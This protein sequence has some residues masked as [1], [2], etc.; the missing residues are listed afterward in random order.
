MTNNST[1]NNDDEL[2]TQP[3]G[4][5]SIN[6]SLVDHIEP[7]EPIPQPVQQD[8]PEAP[9][10]SN[11]KKWPVLMGLLVIFLLIGI[12]LWLAN[13]PKT[14]QLQGM[15]EADS[16]NVATKVPS[17]VNSLLVE[18]GQHVTAGQVLA[19][20]SSPELEAKQ[21]QAEASLQSAR[22]LEQTAKRGSRE[23]NIASLHANWQSLLAQAQ[24]AD[25]TYKRSKNLFEEGVISRQRY[26]ESLAAKNSATQGA[27][28]ARQQYLRAERGST[29]EQLSSADAQ[30]KIA[31]AAVFEATALN[32]E[33]QLVSPVEGEVDK[34]FVNQGELVAAGIPLYT[35]INSKEQWVSIHLKEDE[36]YKLKMGDV[37]HG[38]VPAL[39]TKNV[40]FK[41]SHIA[42]EGSFA[43]WKATRE[44]S[45]YDIRTFAIKLKPQQAI[46]GLRP[47]MSVLFAWPQQPQQQSSH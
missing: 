6:N 11:P 41:V 1:N 9:A 5:N 32:K 45:G 27:E 16:F 19:T 29:P 40:A 17:R 26:E 25:S 23:E 46:E 7:L 15:V 8:T 34:K 35:V 36:F 43:T 33:T 12:G 18:E 39:Q 21:Q 30:V 2:P 28:A 31:Q 20:L 42:A 10:A 24:L 4:D 37:L 44:S 14:G 3:A 47:G 38:D 13:R 22:A